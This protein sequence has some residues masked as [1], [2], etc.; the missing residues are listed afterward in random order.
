MVTL[1]HESSVVVLWQ[2]VL[3]VAALRE[4]LPPPPAWRS[5]LPLVLYGV[6]Q[7]IDQ[8]AGRALPD[9]HLG[10]A[11]GGHDALAIARERCRGD[12]VV[13][14]LERQR[15]LAGRVRPHL[16]G[17]IV[18]RRDHRA[19]VRAERDRVDHRLVRGELAHERAARELPHPH[20]AVTAAGRAQPA[21][22]AER[23][24]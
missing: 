21:R 8:P 24:R 9:P 4:L 10:A 18:A 22:A 14:I 17:S 13:V 15:D 2:A 12:L 20:H 6:D 16:G 3:A 1:V 23:G 11:G 7:P 19:A 5:S